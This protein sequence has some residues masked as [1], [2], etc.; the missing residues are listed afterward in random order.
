MLEVCKVMAESYTNPASSFERAFDNTYE[1]ALA[2]EVNGA[3]WLGTPKAYLNNHGDL[4]WYVP[5]S[6]LDRIVQGSKTITD[7]RKRLDSY[8]RLPGGVYCYE[9][10]DCN[11]AAAP[12]VEV[13]QYRIGPSN[14]APRDED[15]YR[16]LN[17][18]TV[19]GTFAHLA[20]SDE[21]LA[22][23]ARRF[24]EWAA[25]AGR[26]STVQY[27]DA[28]HALVNRA[29]TLHHEPANAASENAVLGTVQTLA[30][31]LRREETQGRTIL[32][33]EL[34]RYMGWLLLTDLSKILHGT[35]IGLRSISKNT[36]A[37]GAEVLDQAGLLPDDFWFVHGIAGKAAAT[38]PA[39]LPILHHKLA[40]ETNWAGLD[41]I[42]AAPPRVTADYIAA[43][44]KRYANDEQRHHMNVRKIFEHVRMRPGADSSV[45]LRK[46]VDIANTV[47]ASYN[48]ELRN[49]PDF[50]ESML[51]PRLK[52]D[53]V[54]Y[55]DALLLLL[56]LTRP[57]NAPPHVTA[58]QFEED[59]A[60]AE[61]IAIINEHS[62][63]AHRMRVVGTLAVQQRLG[64]GPDQLAAARKLAAHGL[65]LR[66][67]M[68]A[69]S[70]GD[71]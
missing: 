50:T 53:T 55:S 28:A 9:T 30:T 14:P 48:Q 54:C 11:D 60:Q 62:R 44:L 61:V 40:D 5:A 33:H 68:T 1:T 26:K 51:L 45:N 37:R 34:G 6:R 46:L 63:R 13:S 23:V 12:K 3:T 71:V 39:A 32:T 59:V 65:A 57:A 15:S 31:A 70:A 42:P 69:L 49:R 8:N 64:L 24:S 20:D 66:D 41:S 27:I 25:A 16:L 17:G 2:A 4:E 35:P 52:Y 58:S 36:Y 7:I 47:T 19:C 21:Q 38:I 22:C 67:I 18:A 29:F 10:W 56:G 43:L